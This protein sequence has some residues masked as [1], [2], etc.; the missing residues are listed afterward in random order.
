MK[1]RLQAGHLRN[2][3]LMSGWDIFFSSPDQFWDLPWVMEFLFQ[4]VK[5]LSI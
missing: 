1:T 4:G 2:Q 3:V 5:H